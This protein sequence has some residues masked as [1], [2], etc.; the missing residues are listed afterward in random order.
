MIACLLHD[1]GHGP[2]SH[3]FEGIFHDKMIRHEDWTPYFLSDYGTKEFFTHYNRSNPRY[4]L[5]EDKF[6]YIA[7]MIMHKPVAK[8]VLADIVSSQLDADR[9]DYLLRDSH[10]C[11]V[12]YGEYDFR[13]ML[14]C[15]TIVEYNDRE[16]LGVTHKGIGVVE[17]YLMA[18]RL[19]TRNIYHSQKKLL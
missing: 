12:R 19:M 14:H 8:P 5:N 16:R 15:M 13:W 17:H 11:G 3:A 2:F 18:R 4:H 6:R 9:F 1:V 10:F 7:E